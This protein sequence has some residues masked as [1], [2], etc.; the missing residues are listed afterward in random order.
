MAKTP[1][2]V[3]T[4]THEG[5]TRT[6]IPTVEYENLMRD[7][8][9]K[10]IEL[11]YPRNPDLDPQLVWRGKDDQD[12]SDLVVTAPPLYIQEKINPKH[13][14]DDLMRQSK[15]RSDDKAQEEAPDLFAD[16]FDGE[17]DPEAKTE[18]YAH[19]Q[20]WTNR[21]ILGDSLQVMASLAEREGLRGKV[22][23]IYFDPPYGINF[24]SNFQPNTQ[25]NTAG[26]DSVSK[27]T[28]EPEMVKAFRDTWLHGT[29]SYLSYLRDRLTVCHDLLSQNGSIF[30]QISDENLHLV[31][32]LLDEI[33]G[34]KNFIAIIPFRKKTMPFGT[35]FIEQ[36]GDFIVWY[37][38]QKRDADGKPFAKYR[39]LYRTMSYSPESGFPFVVNEYG[40]TSKASEHVN[41]SSIGKIATSKSLEPSG[42]MPNGKF[43]PIFNGVEYS[44]P[45][46]GYAT[47]IE[48]LERLSR[49]GRIIP[50][51]NLL[52]YL[53]FADD[54]QYGDLTAPWVDTSG[55]DGKIYVVQTNT[56]V[57]KRCI[58]M[59]T[60]PGDLVLDPTCGS[61]TTAFVC[62]TWGRRWITMDSS[63]V[64]LTLARRRLM[65]AKY[66]AYFLRDSEQGQ[67]LEF[68]EF[69]TSGPNAVPSREIRQGFVY[70]RFPHTTLKSITENA[71]IDEI[72]LSYEDEIKDLLHQIKTVAGS[73]FN[74]WEIPQDT[75]SVSD[76]KLKNLFEKYWKVVRVR[77]SDIDKSISINSDFHYLYD[78]P[79]EDTSKTRVTGPFTV[80]SLS[81]H[82]V[83]AVDDDGEFI[84]NVDAVDGLCA[85][86]DRSDDEIDFGNVIL[87]HLRT[88]GVQQAH[89]EDRIKFHSINPFPGKFIS[90]DGRYDESDNENAPQKRA[91]IFIGP[92][93]GT[94]GRADIVAAAREARDLQFDVLVCCAFNYDAHSSEID[95]LADLPILKARMNPDLH[96]AEEL[97][98]TGAGNLFVV[99][100]EPDIDFINAEDGK[101]QVK[102][103]GVDVFHPSKGEV[104]SGGPESIAAWFIDTDYNEE[105]F[106]VRHAYFLGANDPY[107]QLKSALNAE[108]DEEA[109][110]SLYRDI[111]RP[112]PK[113]ETGRIAVKVIN[114]L[115]DEVMKVFTV[116]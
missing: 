4:I 70:R 26:N 20:N 71:E 78:Q 94:L 53:L 31:R 77:Q 83:I 68:K 69:R 40:Q 17:L 61:G 82:K 36:M 47:T 13:I 93:Y 103:N 64:S 115:G 14:I 10:P 74:R 113:P 88:A 116:E 12:W 18:F 19:D 76:P 104:V 81:P 66:P 112:F 80:E 28:R 6:N 89:K 59:A 109:W 39:K 51:G 50:S 7:E 1:K 49:A 75:E 67:K 101:I 96:M 95:R 99:F 24:S 2:S 42:D 91:A 62:E 86:P 106:F 5:D 110:E 25:Q 60:D 37:A 16:M 97:K 102:I 85:A 21:M 22:Q 27:L 58:L 90:G 108:I 41:W 23:C 100:G 11:K 34:H 87:E 44:F 73:S 8:D 107:K 63:R 105:S 38:K 3:E 54:K 92:E 45:K 56:E 30:F 65:S 43:K 48:G 79:F 32:N 57:V 98:N 72:F 114:H 55:A 15:K 84:D 111:S 35:N 46:N 33:F 9:K 52:R 29:H